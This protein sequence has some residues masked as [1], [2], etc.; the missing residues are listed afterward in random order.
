MGDFDVRPADL[1]AHA[2]R[3]EAVANRVVTARQAGTAV[4]PTSDA[5]GKLC[6]MVPMALGGLQDVLV[7]AIGAAADGL[8]DTAERLREA[9]GAYEATDLSRARVMDRLRSQQ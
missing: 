8:H 1:L 9:A 3:V 2:A 5:Y 6:V 4:R 7:D